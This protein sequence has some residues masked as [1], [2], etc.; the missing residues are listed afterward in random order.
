MR[1]V[2]N[3]STCREAHAME[4]RTTL[5][6]SMRTLRDRMIDGISTKMAAWLFGLILMGCSSRQSLLNSGSLQEPLENR[7]D[8]SEE[9]WLG[10]DRVATV[11][12]SQNEIMSQGEK[13]RSEHVNRLQALQKQA[14]ILIKLYDQE[15]MELIESK[16]ATSF[17]NG[18]FPVSG[19]RKHFP[20]LNN[21]QPTNMVVVLVPSVFPVEER[22]PSLLEI[23]R[24]ID[25][26][27]REGNV[28][29]RVFLMSDGIRSYAL[30]SAGEQ[31]AN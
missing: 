13:P 25:R 15:N 10:E 20:P 1:L 26:F 24:V 5:L 18:R 29:R 6:Q 4:G 30:D 16:V 14:E 31:M 8:P 17:P 23:M 22:Q 27:L 3:L 28:K 12:K 9:A 2:R 7:A 19:L 11:V 21:R